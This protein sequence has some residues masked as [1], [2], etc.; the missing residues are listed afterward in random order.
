MT[1]GRNCTRTSE[2]LLEEQPM[3]TEQGDEQGSIFR[4]IVRQSN[5]H[6]P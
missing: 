5:T 2:W 1:V 4:A 3:V 6:E